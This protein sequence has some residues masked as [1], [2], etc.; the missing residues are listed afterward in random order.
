MI[1]LKT[2]ERKLALSSFLIS[3]SRYQ[4]NPFYK[5]VGNWNSELPVFHVEIQNVFRL[6]VSIL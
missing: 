4:D 2:K 6:M 1:K 3:E 5:L